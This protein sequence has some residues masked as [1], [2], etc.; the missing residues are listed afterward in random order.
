M[1][2][3][4]DILLKYSD[5]TCWSLVLPVGLSQATPEENA[6]FLNSHNTATDL[7][8][9]TEANWRETGK[10]KKE[11]IDYLEN[12]KAWKATLSLSSLL[13]GCSRALFHVL[14]GIQRK[15]ALGSVRAVTGCVT[16]TQ[17]S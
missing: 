9:T 14:W 7:A 16:S 17:D 6:V 4:T 3:D 15:K 5:P 8:Q 10:G 11:Y 1:Y 12:A 2:F 13:S